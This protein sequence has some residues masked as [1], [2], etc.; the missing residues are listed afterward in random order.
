MKTLN[1]YVG[2]DVHKDTTV[3]AAVIARAGKP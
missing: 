1:E 2:Q 3:R